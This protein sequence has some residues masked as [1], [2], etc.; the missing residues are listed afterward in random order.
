MRFLILNADYPEFLWHLYGFDADPR[1]NFDEQL[2]ARTRSLF[3]VADFYTRNL[4]ALGHDAFDIHVNN[5]PMQMA[6]A[7]EHDVGR[8]A[9]SP[10]APSVDGLFTEARPPRTGL[11]RWARRVSDVVVHRQV[12][13]DPWPSRILQAQ[14]EELKPDVVINQAMESICFDFWTQAKETMPFLLV[15]QIASPLPERE[16]F[17]CYDLVVSSLPNYVRFFEG[18][19]VRSRLHRLAFD[20]SVLEQIEDTERTIPFS[21]VGSLSRAHSERIAFLERLCEEA[22][23]QVWGTGVDSVSADSPI[24]RNHRGPAWGAQ[25][26]AILARSQMTFNKHIEIAGEF[27]NNSRLYEAT[28]MG[29]LLLTDSKVN[30]S[31]MFDPVAEVI[32]YD[33]AEEAIAEA[34][35]L[36]AD[37]DRLRRVAEAGRARTL[38]DHTYRHRMEELVTIVEELAG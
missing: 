16:N 30:L 5:E 22:G 21:F 1:A 17:S 23:L 6:W 12:G 37:P 10:I 25:M 19:G 2:A 9:R 3:G 7:R 24:R 27:A 29:A 15:G 13:R 11:G 35:G 20:P 32:S 8:D 31:E 4:R 36:I 26:Y 18:R 14:L 28:G 33:R 34:N 38:R